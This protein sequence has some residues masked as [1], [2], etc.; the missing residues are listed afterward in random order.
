VGQAKGPAP[1]ATVPAPSDGV[2]LSAPRRR[3]FPEPE[4][5]RGGAGAE[6]GRAAVDLR[7]ERS[8]GGQ[9]QRTEG[10]RSGRLRRAH[11]SIDARCGA[12]VDA[13]AA[14][15]TAAATGAFLF[16]SGLSGPLVAGSP[17]AS[18]PRLIADCAPSSGG[19]IAELSLLAKLARASRSIAVSGATSSAIGGE[20]G[21]GGS[22]HHGS[23]EEH[24]ATRAAA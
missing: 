4:V 6:L 20:H 23:F 14:D 2:L 13:E 7:S 8:K 21:A 15:R 18:S 9:Q 16:N 12:G 17:V 10:E 3:L 5:A 1:R 19:G 24:G 22:D 11:Q